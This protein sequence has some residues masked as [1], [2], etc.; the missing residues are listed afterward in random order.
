MATQT[1][2]P[3]I[4]SPAT[5]APLP[6]PKKT[7]VEQDEIVLLA[8]CVFGE[9]RGDTLQ[10]KTGVACV[11][12]N[13][14][15]QHW[16]GAKT[17]ADVILKPYQFD[18]FLANDPNSKKLLTP[19]KYETAAVWDCCYSIAHD[20]HAGKTPDNTAGAVFYFSLP[21]K[22]PPAQWGNVQETVT[23]GKTKFF[24]LT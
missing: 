6:D 23:Y 22:I 16:M 1:A 15:H 21:I 19:L 7:F 10:A 17:W 3:A 8:M 13:R 18:C 2:A 4:P 24:R 20:V 11:V 5:P 9:S 14:L 12:R